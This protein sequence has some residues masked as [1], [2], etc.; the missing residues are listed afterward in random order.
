MLIVVLLYD[1]SI[2]RQDFNADILS[3]CTKKSHSVGAGGGTRDRI[4]TMHLAYLEGHILHLCKVD[5]N[6]G[7]SF[8]CLVFTVISPSLHTCIDHSAS[9]F[10]NLL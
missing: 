7:M 10:S 9:E 2:L 5:N 6:L 8:M 4:E 3:L 1:H